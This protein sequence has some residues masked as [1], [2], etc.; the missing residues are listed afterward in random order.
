ME[1]DGSAAASAGSTEPLEV[2]DVERAARALDSEA[3][4]PLLLWER[5]CPPVCRDAPQASASESEASEAS[6]P[7]GVADAA[8]TMPGAKGTAKTATAKRRRKR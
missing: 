1:S 6:R 7:A 8:A 2:R 5:N 3:S 4:L